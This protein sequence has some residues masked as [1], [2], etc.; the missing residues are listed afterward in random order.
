LPEHLFDRGQFEEMQMLTGDQ[1]NPLLEKFCA[2]GLL[3]IDR[4]RQAAADNDAETVRRCAHKLKG[5][6]GS[7]GA[8][9]LS[10]VCHRMEERARSG[11][12]EGA[13]EAV[14]AIASCLSEVIEVIEKLIAPRG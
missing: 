14:D 10:K 1:F 7:I 12:L 2:D 3:Q 4:M 13:D 6:S 9:M 8:K 11:N 5:S